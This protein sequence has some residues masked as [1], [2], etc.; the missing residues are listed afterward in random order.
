M[1]FEGLCLSVNLFHSS[2]QIDWHKVIPNIPNIILFMSVWSV[3]MFLLSSLILVNLCLLPFFLTQLEIYQSHWSLQ[4]ASL[5]LCWFSFTVI[6]FCFYY[7][8]PTIFLW[9]YFAAFHYQ[10]E[11]YI[12][13]QIWAD[14]KER[15]MSIA[16]W[17]TPSAH[18][19]TP[20]HHLP[21]S[22]LIPKGLQ[23]S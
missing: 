19:F 3:V 6:D 18:L 21:S 11:E 13:N 17:L 7:F 23:V 12:E 16:M 4:W 10:I 20:H 15:C 14:P 8:I 2:Y 5:W 22:Q 1:S 9:V